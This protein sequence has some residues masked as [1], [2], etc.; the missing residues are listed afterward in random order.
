MSGAHLPKISGSRNPSRAFAG[1]LLPEKMVSRVTNRR[2]G[3]ATFAFSK[4]AGYAERLDELFAPAGLGHP[5]RSQAATMERGV[6]LA[7]GRMASEV[8]SPNEN[9]ECVRS[10][11]P[12]GEARFS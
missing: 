9:I 1:T 3:S 4:V 12:S 6:F 11:D 7:D 2:P 10:L 8:Y 5:R